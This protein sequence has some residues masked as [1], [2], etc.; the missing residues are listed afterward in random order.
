MKHRSPITI[1]LAA[2]LS[3][4]ATARADEITDQLDAARKAY[5]A[6]ELR[7]AVDTLNFATAK[8]KEQM[9]VGLLKLLPEPLAGWQAD[10]AES[11]SA[12]LASMIVGT[13]LARR[14][15][16]PDGAEVNLSV[17]ADSPLLPMLTMFL[18]SPFMMQADPNTKP[19]A[20]KGQRGITKHDAQANEYE[21][22]LLIGNRV[23]IQSKGTG[24]AD[25][26]AVQQYIESLDLDAIQKAFGA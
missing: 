12:G 14:Y 2:C 5:A 4:T 17:T 3:L 10:P 13:N 9:T 8:I 25:A 22:T 11:E 18:S 20:Y 1:A 6:G 16:R 15:Y 21:V 24:G 26:Q 23:L 19:Y 7:S